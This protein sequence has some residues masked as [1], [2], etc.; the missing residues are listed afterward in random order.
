MLNRLRFQLGIR[1][2]KLT[3]HWNDFQYWLRAFDVTPNWRE[4]KSDSECRAVFAVSEPLF[5]L[6]SSVFS[7]L[8]SVP[9]AYSSRY[10]YV[11]LAFTLISKH[12]SPSET[13][14]SIGESLTT[15]LP[16]FSSLYSRVLHS[17]VNNWN[18]LHMKYREHSKRAN[19][20]WD[21]R[22]YH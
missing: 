16:Q 2:E 3:K 19:S 18:H 22:W 14:R 20:L 17:S 11:C 7:H 6:Q 21:H 5:S 9:T 15:C 13:K 12:W 1:D 10:T 8:P 4:A